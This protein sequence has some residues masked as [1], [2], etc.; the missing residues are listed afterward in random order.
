LAESKKEGDTMTIEELAKRFV[1]LASKPTLLK[2]EQE[3][4]RGLMRRLKKAGMSNEEISK[5]SKGK[6]TPST[7]KFYT[8]GIRAAHPSPW[9]DAISLLDTLISTDMTLDDV[10]TALTV[11]QNLKEQELTLSQIVELLLA[12]DSASADL[13]TLVSMHEGL[14]ESGLSFKNIVETLSLKKELERINLSLDCLV[15]LVELTKNYGE[16]RQIIEALSQYASLVELKEQ[17]TVTNDGLETINQ[18]LTSAR[19]QLE[20]TENKLSQMKEPLQA[21]QEVTRLGFGESELRELSNLAQKHGTVKKVINAVEAYTDYTEIADKVNKAKAN[22][23]N[24]QA[25]IGELET[26]HSHLKTA[27]TM[28]DTLIHQYKF[29][30]DAISTIFCAAKEYGGP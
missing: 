22:L 8:P 24:V 18:Q 28:C 6:W 25:K 20:E 7:V 21:Y 23:A 14:K 2:A 11:H 29:G 26:S 12:A 4:A 27:T 1:I 3:E 5:L 30:L 16:P 13:G 19:Q 15:P 10:T 9:Q 17:I